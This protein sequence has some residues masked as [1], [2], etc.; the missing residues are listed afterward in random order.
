MNNFDEITFRN[1]I[2]TSHDPMWLIIDNKFQFCNHAAVEALGYSHEDELMNTHPSQ[3][4]PKYQ[5]DGMLSYEKAEANLFETR[6]KGYKRFEWLHTT[7]DKSTLPVE[8]TLN[9]MPDHN[10]DVYFCVWRDI[11][12]AKKLEHELIEAKLLAESANKAKSNFLSMMSHELRTPLNAVIG[13]SDVLKGKH[14]GPLN[15]KQDGFVESIQRGGKSLL[16][17]IDDILSMVEIDQDDLELEIRPLAA[18]NIITQLIDKVRPYADHKRMRI[19]DYTD[20]SFE[21]AFFGDELRV[22]QIL[23]HFMINAIKYNER[24]GNIFIGANRIDNNIRFHV[25]DDGLGI[26][27]KHIENIFEPFDRGDKKASGVEGT[28]L[29]LSICQKLAKRMSGKCGVSSAYGQGTT[30]W[31]DLP[32]GV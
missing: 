11:S 15:E 16:N 28:G 29:G 8:V 21:C 18:K 6:E 24:H 30:F 1:M 23:T 14:C 17:L 9:H 19:T 5:F 22:T 10:K 20:G 27:E 12:K 4:S 32:M 25:I 13:Y 7:K 2:E 31:L 26:E 3:L